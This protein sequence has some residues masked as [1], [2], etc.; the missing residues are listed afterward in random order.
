MTARALPPH[1]EE[2]APAPG[3]GS[4]DMTMVLTK[5]LLDWSRGAAAAALALVVAAAL[6][7]AAAPRAEAQDLTTFQ[8]RCL[9]ATLDNAPHAICETG[10]I[11]GGRI[12]H[13]RFQKDGSTGTAEANF[14]SFTTVGKAAAVLAVVDRGNRARQRQVALIGQ[15]LP[16]IIEAARAA[17][18]NN[19]FGIG[20]VSDRFE[21]L[22]QIGAAR[23]EV[24]RVS[25]AIRADSTVGDAGRLVPDA[26]RQLTLAQ[27]ERF[28]LLLASDGK[29]DD[30]AYG[31][32]DV[33]RAAR[34]AKVIVIA[35]AYRERPDAAGPESGSLR[36]LAEETGGL[37]LDVGGANGR[38]DD[39]SVA[40]IAQFIGSGGTA[41]FPLN[42]NDPR[43]RYLITLEFESGRS[44]SGAFFADVTA[45][46]AQPAQPGAQPGAPA[47]GQP[48]TVRPVQG[49]QTQGGNAPPA[50]PA[51]PG[52]GAPARPG[53]STAT[54][55]APPADA[56]GLMERSGFDNI[57]DWIAGEWRDRP[58]LVIG[59]PAVL[60]L[61]VL[62]LVFLQWRRRKRLPVFA[63]LELAD[64][65]RTRV[66]ITSIGVRIGRH[67]DNDI[68]FENKSVHRYHAVLGR[69]VATGQYVVS[70]VSR[71]LERSNGVLV[72][73]E[74]VVKAP[75]A[76]GDVVELGEVKF[77]FLY[78]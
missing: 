18:P 17:G 36:R 24:T 74:L 47:G 2:Q 75:L 65:K 61:I 53:G 67:S 32:E 22:A 23:D 59:I 27:A 72:N 39:A 30:R 16:R 34:D 71:D 58:T 31:R 51:Q 41:T 4:M 78:A 1:P 55:T 64:D 62:A 26:I 38:L 52:A 46:Q 57:R 77:R 14:L 5:R 66:P 50:G 10:A 43:G 12:T 40:R 73:G 7:L 35:L 11:P 42:R 15:D 6:A 25:A 69:D 76:N 13:V 20:Q 8:P 48:G 3:A 68:R 49:P 44:V 54:P 33:I 29:T 28:V 63:W 9:V 19:R 45:A 21:M 37:Y 60:A 70:D 56:P